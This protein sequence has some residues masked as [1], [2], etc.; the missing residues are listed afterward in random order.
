MAQAELQERRYSPEE[1]FALEEASEVR[2]EYFEG[3]MF[4][5]AGAR[6]SH[7]LLA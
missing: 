6:K 3:E 4:V 7:N 1:Y 5:M 2:H